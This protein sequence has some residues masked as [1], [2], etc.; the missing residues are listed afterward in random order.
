MKITNDD[1][2][3]LGD[4][5]RWFV[6]D[7]RVTGFYCNDGTIRIE[8]NK[9]NAPRLTMFGQQTYNSC[10]GQVILHSFNMRWF[11][12]SETRDLWFK[13]FEAVLVNFFENR[14]T[15]AQCILPIRDTDAYAGKVILEILK[16]HGFVEWGQ[17]FNNPTHNSVLQMYMRPGL[18]HATYKN[19]VDKGVEDLFLYPSKNQPRPTWDYTFDRQ[20]HEKHN[21][22]RIKL[23]DEQIAAQA[24]AKKEKLR[25][26]AEKRRATLAAKKA[27][28]LQEV[29]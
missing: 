4:S 2:Q 15:P 22:Q 25:I 21:T 6:K 10:C 29:F 17:P 11:E 27:A 28:K 14:G 26:A 8:T 23:T 19:A 1:L 16:K 7:E 3:K 24:A 5:M 9:G 13:V 20:W 18:Y 12:N